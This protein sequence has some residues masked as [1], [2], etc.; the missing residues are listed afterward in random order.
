MFGALKTVEEKNLY[1][2]FPRKLT[3]CYC[4]AQTLNNYVIDAEGFM[5]KC[6]SKHFESFFDP[7]IKTV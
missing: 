4:G 1:S 2:S 3:N 6:P 5:Y 7:V